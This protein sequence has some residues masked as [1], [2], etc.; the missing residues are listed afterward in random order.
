MRRTLDIHQAALQDLIRAAAALN[1]SRPA[2]K[3]SARA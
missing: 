1:A 2:K 3:R